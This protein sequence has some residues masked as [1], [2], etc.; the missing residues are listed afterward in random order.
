LT[1]TTVV[2]PRGNPTRDAL[3][4]VK[5]ASELRGLTFGNGIDSLLQGGLMPNKFNFLYGHLADSWMNILCGNFVRTFRKSKAL[6]V[7]AA[8]CFD[9]YLIADRCAPIKS[10]SMLRKFLEQIIV[11]RAFSCYQ[12]RVVVMKQ[13][14]QKYFKRW[15]DIHA[16]FVTGID[17]LFNEEDNPADEIDALQLLMAN[18]LREIATTKKSGGRRPLF[19]V[20]SSKTFVKYFVDKSDTA[21]KL[22]QEKGGKEMAMLSK[23]WTR[24]FAAARL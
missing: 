11:V 20:S 2:N 15:E 7:D 3:T 21:I 16:I 13:I 10:E 17:A 6:F 23:H 18:S 22:Y 1:V 14:E 19:V 24:Q 4:L 9:P 12:L 5:R 8:N